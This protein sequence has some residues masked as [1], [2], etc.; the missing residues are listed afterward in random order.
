MESRPRKG[1]KIMMTVREVMTPRVATVNTDTTLRDAARQMR[2]LD[3]GVLPV[4]DNDKLVGMV[5]DR[6]ITIRAVAE[7]KNPDQVSVREAMT[8][9]LVFCYEDQGLSEVGRIMK[10]RQVRRVVVLNRQDQ[11][12]GI[13][14][15]GDLV[16]QSG[17]EQMGGDVLQSVSRPEDEQPK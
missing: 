15:I 5:T 4:Q 3:V 16:V 17:D 2:N 12:V 10:E 7:G 8:P 1:M 6:D 9:N 14:S 13:C 11:L